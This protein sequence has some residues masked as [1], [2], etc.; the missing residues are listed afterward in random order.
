MMSERF[1]ACL[2]T[3]FLT[4]FFSVHLFMDMRTKRKSILARSGAGGKDIGSRATI[5]GIMGST[6]AFWVVF[7][8]TPFLI[9]FGVYG[10]ISSLL[11]LSLFRTCLS[12]AIGSSLMLLGVIIAD[13][14]RVSRGHM[15][16]STFDVPE[17]FTFTR[18]GAYAVVRHPMYLSY[19]LMFAGLFLLTAN[20]IL[21]FCILGYP[22]YY[23]MACREEAFLEERFP[24]Y[25]KYR[26]KVGMFF[27]RLS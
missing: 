22:S 5:L 23:L 14:G 17:D 4:L 24:E 3:I 16:P 10:K 20:S 15:A 26:E 2:L 25:E 6:F 7:L 27:P 1:L 11:T 21:I 13:W 19:Y 9:L 18:H 8:A 12:Q